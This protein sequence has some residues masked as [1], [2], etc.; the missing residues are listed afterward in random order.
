MI[1]VRSLVTETISLLLLGRLQDA[2]W[3]L[4]IEPQEFLETI[5]S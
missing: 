4:R 3:G 1:N 5:Q 2:N